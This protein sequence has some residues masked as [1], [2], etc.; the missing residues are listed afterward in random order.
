M[1]GL[2]QPGDLAQPASFGFQALLD[3]LIVVDLYEIRRHYLPPAHSVLWGFGKKTRT[4]ERLSALSWQKVEK[5]KKAEGLCPLW[6]ERFGTWD[7]RPPETPKACYG[8]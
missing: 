3:F 2:V 1:R 8:G 4:N 5:Q 6:V 7:V